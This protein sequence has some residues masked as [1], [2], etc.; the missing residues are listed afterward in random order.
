MA[1]QACACAKPHLN[2]L[3]YF[4]IKE[5]MKLRKVVLVKNLGEAGAGGDYQDLLYNI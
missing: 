4:F 1:L 5:D 3:G 2:T